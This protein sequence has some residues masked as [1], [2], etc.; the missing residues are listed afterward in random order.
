MGILTSRAP[1][2]HPY[3]LKIRF[4]GQSV[5]DVELDAGNRKWLPK[6]SGRVYPETYAVPVPRTLP[7][8]RYA[9]KFKLYANEE[10]RDVLVALDP[11]LQD[12]DSYYTVTSVTVRE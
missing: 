12:K 5:A 3:R 7:P 1:A 2:Y 8:G 4:S 6:P 9:L 10:R 11:G